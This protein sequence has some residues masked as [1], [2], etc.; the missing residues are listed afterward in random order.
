MYNILG[1][2]DLPVTSYN[3]FLQLS[4]YPFDLYI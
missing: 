1:G 4:N 2:Y 3:W